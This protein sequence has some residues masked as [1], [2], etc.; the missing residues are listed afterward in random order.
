MS[1]RHESCRFQIDLQ[2]QVCSVDKYK[3]RFEAMWRIT[4]LDSWQSGMHR[5][6]E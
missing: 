3:A 1:R 2:D 4:R 5:T 6:K